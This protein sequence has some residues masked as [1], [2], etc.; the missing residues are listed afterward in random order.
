MFREVTDQ[1]EILID[2]GENE[3]WTK[4]KKTKYIVSFIVDDVVTVALLYV[5]LSRVEVLLLVLIV[6]VV[7]VVVVGSI[8]PVVKSSLLPSIYS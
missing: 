8:L 2:T 5:T 7:V 3:I 6:M 4:Q 1:L